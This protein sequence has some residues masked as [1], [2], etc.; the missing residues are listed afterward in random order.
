MKKQ[1]TDHAPIMLQSFLWQV[2]RCWLRVINSFLWLS[3]KFT[4]TKSTRSEYYNR[5]VY[6]QNFII[7]QGHTKSKLDTSSVTS[8]CCTEN[9]FSRD[10]NKISSC[11]FDKLNSTD[12][13][14]FKKI[15]LILD[16]C[17]G[18]NKN[19]SIT[20]MC[21][22]WLSSQ[23]APQHINAAT[24]RGTGLPPPGVG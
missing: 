5:Q 18:Q 20:A 16:G 11:V 3:K 1:P 24:G 9:E 13:S 15:L 23:N 6:I 12:M 17:A 4:Y 2:R 14:Q 7:V 22:I 10:S 8:Y 21:Q 19:P